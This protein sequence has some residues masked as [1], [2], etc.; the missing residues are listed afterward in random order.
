MSIRIAGLRMEQ[1]LDVTVL[2]V[3]DRQGWQS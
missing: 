2:V 1:G 3:R